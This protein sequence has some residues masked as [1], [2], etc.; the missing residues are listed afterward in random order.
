M[1]PASPARRG[2]A[3][4]RHRTVG[5]RRNRARAAA[6][7]AE[8]NTFPVARAAALVSPPKG[9]VAV[10]GYD[11]IGELGRGGMG[12]V[13]KARQVKLNRIVALSCASRS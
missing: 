3:R 2:A 10:P 12:V 8:R 11:V 9:D 1:K 5:R 13:Y 7:A 4:R 6:T